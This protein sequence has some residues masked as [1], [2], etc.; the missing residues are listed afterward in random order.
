MVE[1]LESRVSGIAALAEPARLALYE[2]VAAQP[3]PVTREQAAAATGLAHHNV[4]FHLDRLVA[5]GLLAVEHRR[6]AGRGGPGAGRP[7]KHYRRVEQELS[8]SLPPRSYELA[9][10]ILAAAVDATAR[11]AEPVSDAVAREARAAGHRIARTATAE[12]RD[13]DAADVPGGLGTAVRVL[14]ANGYEPRVEAGRVVMANC[15]FHALSQAHT[16][17]VCGLNLA[18]IAGLTDELG[19]PDSVAVLDPAPGRCCVTLVPR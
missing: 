9:G 12:P 5:D 13:D 10:E 1:S 11:G 2:Y 16:E 4:K 7:A 17:L 19:L 18:L 8:V 6:P 14:A 3:E 15:P